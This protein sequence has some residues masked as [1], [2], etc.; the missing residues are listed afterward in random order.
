MTAGP[1]ATAE[2]ARH[3]SHKGSSGDVGH[4]DSLS[5][6]LFQWASIA[7]VWQRVSLEGR[8]KAFNTFCRR[9]DSLFAMKR[10]GKLLR[11][12][13]KRFNAF[14]SVPLSGRRSKLFRLEILS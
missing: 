4:F 9:H 14:G 1:S 10:I 5:E 6:T 13:R 7:R 2:T 3:P 8:L 12:C 11:V